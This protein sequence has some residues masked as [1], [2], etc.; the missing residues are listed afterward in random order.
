[1]KL[2][3]ILSGGQ[4]GADKAG[5]EVAKELGLETGGTAPK[6]YRTE[7]GTDHS[8][9]ELGLVE[10][11]YW[12]YQPRTKQNVKDADITVWFG[13]IGSPGYWC[14]CNAAKAYH[15]PFIENPT[16]EQFRALAEEY[17]VINTAGNRASTNPGV[18]QLVKDTIREALRG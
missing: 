1:M 5:L 2:R 4:T 17:E 3:K 11:P 6:G 15:K 10:S 18:S 9:K 7:S 16:S 12:Q 14:T 13:N 8:L